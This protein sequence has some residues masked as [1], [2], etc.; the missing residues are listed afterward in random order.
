M[1]FGIYIYIYIYAPFFVFIYLYMYLFHTNIHTYFPLFI[2]MYMLSQ[3]MGISLFRR[4][5]TSFS[6]VI[7]F[8]CLELCDCGMLGV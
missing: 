1:G 8:V 5:Q 7:V 2:L 6:F 3:F 4:P